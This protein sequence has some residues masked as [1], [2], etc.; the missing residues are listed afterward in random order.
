MGAGEEKDV[1]QEC[2]YFDVQ[3]V[4]H[5]SQALLVTLAT[6]CVEKT[7][8]DFFSHGQAILPEVKQELLDYLQKQCD[9][10]TNT[11]VSPR[12]GQVKFFF[13]NFSNL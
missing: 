3:Q 12:V 1:A 2:G 6:A 8:G 7:S 4:Q 9:T 11:V 5:I 13:C 10:Y